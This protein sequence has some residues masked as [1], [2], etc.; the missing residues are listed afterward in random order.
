MGDV[1]IAS[2]GIEDLHRAYPNA[3]IDLST[4]PPW[5]KLYAHDPRVTNLYTINVRGP[6]QVWGI[7]EWLKVVKR[8]RYDLVVD[9]QTTD[10][11]RLLLTLLWLVGGQIRHRAG[12]LAAFPYNMKRPATPNRHA[13]G[14]MGATVRAA[15]AR[16]LTPRPVLHCPPER[17]RYVEDLLLRHG[18][19]ADAFGVFLP[20]SQAAG[21]LKR[22]GAS[23]FVA[24]G[25]KLHQLG[26]QRILIIGGPEETEECERIAVAG[27]QWALN[28]CG[29]TELLD[30]VPLCA[31]AKFIV[32]ND[33][34]TAHVSASCPKPMLIICGPTDPARVLPAGPN[35]AA[36]QAELP[37][38]NCYQ[39][40][41][42]HHSC[43]AWVTPDMVVDKLRSMGALG[44][45]TGC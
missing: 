15:G 39:K 31:N 9:F 32:G 16:A 28:L 22:W 43:M 6:K 3:E 19:E 12:N 30:L 33:T 5:D 34:G 18:L 27:G 8:R 41:C 35:V 11:S 45:L 10:R 20:G 1:A 7:V 14:I 21:Y 40:H 23:R 36:L 44:H 37:C 42:S 38:I 29:Q 24:L 26:L 13:M 17:Q 25:E 4:L 2:A